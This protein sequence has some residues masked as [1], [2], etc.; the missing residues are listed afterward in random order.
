LAW[1]LKGAGFL[2]I[3]VFFGLIAFGFFVLTQKSNTVL[4][5]I[6][7]IPALLII[8]P[9]IQ[10]FPIG[11]GLKV[12]F[13]SAILTALTFGLLL[14][15][16]GAY[17]KKGM[18]SLLFLAIASVF[19]AKAHVQSGYE[20]GK[21]KS[22]SLLYIYN[23]DTQKANWV[24]Y[25]TNLDSWTQNYLGKQPKTADFMKDTPLFSKYNS[26]FTYAAEAPKKE[27]TPPTIEFLKD[28]TAGNQRVVKIKITPN[29]NVNRYDV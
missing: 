1:G 24:T 11:L 21:A 15:V 3:P 18:W 29:R 17:A 7:G 25:D 20:L 5:L 12:L 23:A 28:E 16:F 14:P 27:L 22:N 4:N 19:F 8:A 26:G 13:G 2:I 9:F 6:C 10:M